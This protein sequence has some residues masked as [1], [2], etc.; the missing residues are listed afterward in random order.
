MAAALKTMQAMKSVIGR[1]SATSTTSN[2]IAAMRD[3]V[4]TLGSSVSMAHHHRLKPDTGQPPDRRS[5]GASSRTLHPRSR[6]EMRVDAPRDQPGDARR[7]LEIVQAGLADT[8]RGA[9]MVQQRPLAA[10]ADAGDFVKLAGDQRF[11]PPGP[12]GGDGK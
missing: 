8:A 2:G 12:V 7:R 9:E 10:R 6:V 5:P 3:R 1:R 11:R 4:R